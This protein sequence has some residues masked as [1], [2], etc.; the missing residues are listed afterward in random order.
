MDTADWLTELLTHPAKTA[1]AGAAKVAKLVT[2][3]SSG[4]GTPEA[5]SLSLTSLAAAGSETEAAAAPSGG[6]PAPP[7][8]TATLAAAW[9]ASELCKSRLAPST[10]EGTAAPSLELRSQFAKAQYG[11]PYPRSPWTHFGSLLK[12]QVDITLR[13]KLFVTARVASAIVISLVS[14][15]Y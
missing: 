10:A 9:R 7:T 6:K 5:S 11:R 2:S 4:M 1:A 13:N 14:S 15:I 12:R 3:A 8:T